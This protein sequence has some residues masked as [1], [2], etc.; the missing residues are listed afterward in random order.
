MGPLHHD[1][2][3]LL[4]SWTAPHPEQERLRQA[5]LEHLAAHPDGMWRENQAAHL[6]ASAMVV[7]PERRQVL[8]TLHA[9][10]EQWLQL[11]GHCEPGDAG[12]AQAALREAGEESGIAGL[13]LGGDAQPVVLDRHLVP[14]HGPELPRSAHLDVQFVAIA[15]PGAQATRSSESTDLRWFD[16]RALP[17]TADP[18]VRALVSRSVTVLG[19]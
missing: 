2:V 1:A 14:C 6:T 12:L 11:G 9:K 18:S 3:A 16:V 10:L 7:A 5:Y 15:P 17:E 4:R 13:R 19:L 8:L